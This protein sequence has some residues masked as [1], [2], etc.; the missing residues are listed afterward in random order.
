VVVLGIIILFIRYH[1]VV[2]DPVGKEGEG[3]LVKGPDG[4]ELL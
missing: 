4:P 2:P 3:M 1:P